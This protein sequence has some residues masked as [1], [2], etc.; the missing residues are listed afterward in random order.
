MSITFNIYPSPKPV[1]VVSSCLCAQMAPGW[2]EAYRT[3]EGQRVLRGHANTACMFCHGT[4]VENSFMDPEGTTCNYSNINA[5]TVLRALRLPQ[6]AD[7]SI[8]IAEF[9]TRLLKALNT[10]L[11][12]YLDPAPAPVPA[13]RAVEARA[14]YLQ[15]PVMD[16][17]GLTSR[18]QDLQDMAVL[19]QQLGATHIC[20]GLG[21]VGGL[22]RRPRFWYNPQH[23][24]LLIG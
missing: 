11:E 17:H 22:T 1:P 15:G 6:E 14:R 18:L 8:P 16:A 10:S 5:Y 13:V 21:F 23:S 4:G 7:G 20:W 9:R 19:G 2:A 24:A 12:P 3:E